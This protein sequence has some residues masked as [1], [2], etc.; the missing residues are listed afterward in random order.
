MSTRQDR[1]AK[2]KRSKKK[3]AAKAGDKGVWAGLDPQ[4][5]RRAL[6]VAAAVI[7]FGAVAVGAAAGLRQLDRQVHALPHFGGPPDIVLQDVPEGLDP[8]IRQALTP[9][10][11]ADWSEPALCDRIGRQ[12]EANA[13]VRKVDSVR[14]LPTG[15][16]A[17]HCVYRT[18][19]ALVQTGGEFILID[20]QAVR[21]PG[22]YPYH[23]SWP[24]IQGVAGVPPPA[25]RTWE[26]PDLS[27]AVA[28]LDRLAAE[29]FADQLTAVL[30][31]NFHGRIDAR[32]AHIEL[33]TDRAGG[34]I[35]WGSAPGE[36]VAENTADQKLAILRRNH[37]LYGR[38]DAGR[39]V[40]DVTMFPDRFTTPTEAA[41]G[42]GRLGR[43]QNPA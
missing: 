17:I 8:I 35:I 1:M 4:K 34:R 13:W 11:D 29:P 5:K 24:L 18:P 38:I 43:G 36:E 20:Q 15:R 33:A 26:A 41:A 28:V 21:L 2:R 25:G 10:L 7:A 14:R 16:I 39:Q 32:E 23:A 19:M 30:V 22:S 12:L 40:I 9:V 3:S 6:R 31:H 37:E 27:A 42:G